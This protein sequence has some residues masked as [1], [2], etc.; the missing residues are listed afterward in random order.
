MNRGKAV[1]YSVAGISALVL[2][3][4]LALALGIGLSTA[5]SAYAQ[6]NSSGDPSW[7]VS[8]SADWW[9]SSSPSENDVRTT[10]SNGSLKLSG[11]NAVGW[12]S[13]D[14]FP[15]GFGSTDNTVYGLTSYQND[16]TAKNGPTITTGKWDNALLFDGTNSVVVP[17]DNSESVLVRQFDSG[18][19]GKRVQGIAELDNIFVPI[20]TP[21]E[22]MKLYKYNP[23]SGKVA[24]AKE[25]GY[26]GDAVGG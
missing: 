19:G 20:T 4:A 9:D 23:T 26:P 18:T 10:I 14:S 25:F 17:D 2:A 15:S 11:E 1:R 8:S 16:G 24:L 3:S 21:S 22:N 7:T 12:W 5:P 6:S 13:M